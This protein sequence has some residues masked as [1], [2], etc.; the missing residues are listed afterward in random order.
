MNILNI[1]NRLNMIV[2]GIL[3]IALA[4]LLASCVSTHEVKYEEV[5][6]DG[7]YISTHV[8]ERVPPGGKKLS[9]GQ[10]QAGVEADGSWELLINGQADTDA[11]GTA[12]FYR[13]IITA[14]IEAGIAAGL[15]AAASGAVS[16]ALTG[17]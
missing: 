10:T 14:A 17:P 9:E 1:V 5:N 7:S 13:D 2:M 8:I 15:A 3:L 12:D 6:A 16:P 11:Q 4:L